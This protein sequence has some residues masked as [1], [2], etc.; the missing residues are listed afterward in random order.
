MN[1]TQHGY[2]LLADIAGYTSYVASTELTH[3]QEILTE[4]LELIIE[5]FKPLLT[6]SKIEG[7][8]IF[9]YTPETK[10]PRG[11][12]ILELIESTYIAFRARRDAA[13][14]GTT[15]TCN[16]CRN[17]PNLDLKFISHHGDY[18]VQNI[19]GTKELV[20]SDVNLIH[21]L[22]KNHVS[23]S[24]G[25]HAYA[26]FTEQSFRH[27]DAQPENLYEQTESYEHLGEV[28]TLS[29]DLH[30]R[31]KEIMD[32][33]RVFISPTEAHQILEYTYVAPP[34]IIWEWFNDPA[35][36][37]QW[38][39]SDIVPI[40]RVKGRVSAGARNH[41]VHGKDQIIVEDILDIRPIEYYTARHTPQGFSTSILLTFHFTPTESGGTNLQLRVKG[42]I[43]QMPEWFKKIFCKMIVRVQ[44]LKTWRLEAIDKL[45]EDNQK[46]VNT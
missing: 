10:I 31:Y 19:A 45:V 26:L 21:R 29:M 38:M 5:R 16:A 42:E 12:A 4:L 20:G 9:A 39:H 30:T 34:Q 44:L 25:W 40:L 43:P 22:L 7:D 24:K 11:E 15:C 37:G 13:H 35:K 46:Q 2:L 1:D 23:E 14:R 32:A 17:I 27:L 41:C 8:A 33:R 3:S 6:I 36:R 18:F 28:R